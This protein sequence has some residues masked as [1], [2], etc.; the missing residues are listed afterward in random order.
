MTKNTLLNGILALL[1]AGP[2][3]AQDATAETLGGAVGGVIGILIVVVVGAVIGWVASLIVKGTGSGLLADVLY[4]VG[5]AF[6]AGYLLPLL[7]LPL[8]TIGSIIA[9]VVGAI[10]LILIVRLVRKG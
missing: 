7:G 3:F 4:G 8:G 5:G 10:L 6:L 2:A 1:V 9:A